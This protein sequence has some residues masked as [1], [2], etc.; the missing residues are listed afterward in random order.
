L[1]GKYALASG[2]VEITYDTGAK[3]VLQGP[4]EYVVESPNGGFM[5]VGKLTGSATTDAARGLTIRTPTAT[6]RDIGTEFGVDVNKDGRTSS[7]VFRGAI[8]VQ[9]AA[10]QGMQPGRPIRLT[11]NESVQ[12]ERQLGKT[13]MTVQRGTVDAASFVRPENLPTL[14]KEQHLKAFRRWQTYSRKLRKDPSLLAYYD[15]Q[16]E[17]GLPGVLRNVATGGDRSADGVIENVTWS[18]GRMPG[19]HSLQFMRPDDCVRI[20]LPQRADDLT[21]AAW[22]YVD[23]LANEPSGLLSGS[24]GGDGQVEWT[25]GADRHVRFQVFPSKES[26]CR[27]ASAFDNSHLRRWTHLAVVWD[28]VA[29]RARLYIDGQVTDEMKLP[30]GF[31]ICIG[32]SVIG[33]ARTDSSFDFSRYALGD[34][35]AQR[36]W[37]LESGEG[38]RITTGPAGS[39][40]TTSCVTGPGDGWA[41]GKLALDSPVAFTRVDTNVVQQVSVFVADG[42]TGT[43]GIAGLVPAG[44][45]SATGLIGISHTAADTP[46]TYYRM[47]TADATELQGDRLEVGHWYDIR[48]TM[49]FSVPGGLARLSYRDQTA[50]QTGFTPDAG[51][52]MQSIRMGLTPDATGRYLFDA[53]SMRASGNAY[54]DNYSL[55]PCRGNLGN[56]MSARNF[57]GRIDELA[58]F[59]RPLAAEEIR[60][61]FECG[62]PDAVPGDAAKRK[63]K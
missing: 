11:E 54:L 10:E 7:Y 58:I 38:L 55:S 2:L 8:E 61:M 18:N 23:A 37:V 57:R 15:C 34:L 62:S 36:G 51:A 32:S 48:L 20:H 46:R 4:V 25:V 45:G 33:A 12:I 19:K 60:R 53:L 6:I 3:V 21:L 47:T 13:E 50:G 59:G 63:R 29:E 40:N 24:A 44:R 16:L 56:A 52:G 43:F 5:S 17:Q 26:V 39:V 28:H 42:G 9:V 49:D 27:S 41:A 14:A 31:P 30:G 35:A 1:G 22:V